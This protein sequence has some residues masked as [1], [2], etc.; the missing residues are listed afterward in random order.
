M[1]SVMEGTNAYLAY[2]A[3]K[4]KVNWKLKDILVVWDYPDVFPEIR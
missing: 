2:V 4:P 3:A 1:R